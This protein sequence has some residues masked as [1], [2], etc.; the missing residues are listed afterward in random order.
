MCTGL[1]LC[2]HRLVAPCA[3]TCD[4]VC[5]GLQQCVHI[6]FTVRA[7]YLERIRK[8]RDENP[9]TKVIRYRIYSFN[10]TNIAKKQLDAI[11]KTLLFS[12]SRS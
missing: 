4:S 7:Q 10:K 1:I 8:K 11:Q 9:F 5:T 2:V 3:Q 6:L 12:V